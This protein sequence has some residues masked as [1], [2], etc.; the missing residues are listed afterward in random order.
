MERLRSE[1]VSKRRI[2]VDHAGNDTYWVVISS[3]ADQ[4]RF[5]PSRKMYRRI[6]DTLVTNSR[7]YEEIQRARVI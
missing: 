2:T 5:S 4:P 3:S 1:K 6:S 7:L